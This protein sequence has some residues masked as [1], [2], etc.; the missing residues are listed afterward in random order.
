MKR[1]DLI[2]IMQTHIEGWS[3]LPEDDINYGNGTECCS[4]LLDKMIN[5]KVITNLDLPPW[6]EPYIICPKCSS[7]APIMATGMN[8]AVIWEC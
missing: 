8:G 7:K 3:N 1:A 6:Q 2:N 4:Q 5:L